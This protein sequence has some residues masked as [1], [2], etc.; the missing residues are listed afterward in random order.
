M[1]PMTPTHTPAPRVGDVRLR[2][3]V[4]DDL[5]RLYELQGDPD[6]CAMAGVR[7]RSW[8]SFVA[9]WDK[10]FADPNVVARAILADG[11]LAGSIA[12]FRMAEGAGAGLD[13]VG[14]WIARDHWGRGVASRALAL[15][16]AEVPRRPLHAQVAAENAASLKVLA[17]AGFTETG[18]RHDPG[19]DRY[20]AGE[21]V[22]L[23][24]A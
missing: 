3:V 22:E 14:Y 7:P 18:R 1:S 11:A 20:V 2:P 9:V 23:T 4:R 17:R 8:E 6:S 15:F 13:S 16:V 10:S 21:V 24:L 19:S 12:C 5:P